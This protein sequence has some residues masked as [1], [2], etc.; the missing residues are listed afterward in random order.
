[1]I[2]DRLLISGSVRCLN[3]KE[4]QIVVLEY[5]IFL[6]Q[7]F[8]DIIDDN[9]LGKMSSITNRYSNVLYLLHSIMSNI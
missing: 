5:F 6:L 7:M 1:M 4:Q 8:Y 9:R 2:S 3:T